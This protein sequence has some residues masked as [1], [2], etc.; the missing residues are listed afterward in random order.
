MT[1]QRVQSHEARRL[2]PPSL[3]LYFPEA[4]FTKP[5]LLCWSGGN[6]QSKLSILMPITLGL[7]DDRNANGWQPLAPG[8]KARLGQHIHRHVA[9]PGCVKLKVNHKPLAFTA[10]ENA[11]GQ[12]FG[13]CLHGTSSVFQPPHSRPATRASCRA[14]FAAMIFTPWSNSAIA[15]PRS[16]PPFVSRPPGL[17]ATHCQQRHEA[18]AAGDWCAGSTNRRCDKLVQVPV[19]HPQAILSG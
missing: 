3:G 13:R 16:G 4:E 10:Q 5:Q 9:V 18:L 17:F 11:V 6:A 12:Q 1:A 19:F 7:Q 8:Q 2:F 15:D 14:A